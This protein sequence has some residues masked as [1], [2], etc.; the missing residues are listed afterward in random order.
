VQVVV[1]ARIVVGV[2]RVEP[3]PA[4]V[5][6]QSDRQR[7][8]RKEAEPDTDVAAIVE[9]VA[10]RSGRDGIAPATVSGST[11]GRRRSPRKGTQCCS[12][13]IADRRSGNIGSEQATVNGA[14]RCKPIF[15]T[16]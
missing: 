12:R 13:T 9:I 16:D 11:G 5:D 1:T 10:G 15:P 2:A 4:A 8:R 7:A 3:A 14:V 6:A